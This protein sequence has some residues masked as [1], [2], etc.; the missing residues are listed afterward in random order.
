[1]NVAYD[2]PDHAVC[3][4]IHCFQIPLGVFFCGSR[5]LESGSVVI[6][7]HDLCSM[8]QD[9]SGFVVL[10]NELGCVALGSL[11]FLYVL[12]QAE[13]LPVLLCTLE[14]TLFCK[15]GDTRQASAL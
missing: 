8:Q 4:L 6:L 15:N 3:T 12:F 13:I 10:C 7:Q 1:M 5:L 9:L 14:G 11:Q 2:L